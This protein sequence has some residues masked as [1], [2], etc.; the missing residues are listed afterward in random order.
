MLIYPKNLL[1][2]RR[3]GKFFHGFQ[4]SGKRKNASSPREKIPQKSLEKIPDTLKNRQKSFFRKSQILKDFLKNFFKSAVPGIGSALVFLGKKMP[5]RDSR[6]FFSGKDFRKITVQSGNISGNLH[7]QDRKGK[8]AARQ[9]GNRT[10]FFLCQRRE[11][12]F[13]TAMG[14]MTFHPPASRSDNTLMF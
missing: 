13:H 11:S 14:D 4:T 5:D 7:S 6:E 10:L 1:S 2:A 12:L 3:R 9:C 8:R